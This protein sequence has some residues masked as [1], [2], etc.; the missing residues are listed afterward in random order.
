[1]VSKRMYNN[2]HKSN[3]AT[4]PA[5]ASTLGNKKQLAIQQYKMLMVDCKPMHAHRLA[6]RSGFTAEEEKNALG[7]AYLGIMLATRYD[8]KPTPS[9]RRLA[10][11]NMIADE[12]R[13]GNLNGAD[14]LARLGKIRRKEK[15]AA[16]TRAILNPDSI[17][18]EGQ[19]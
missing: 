4:A 14:M 1:M 12:A 11:L 18:F 8:R 15:E 6:Q 16:I 5:N 9:S 13:N 7:G 2:G 17:V 3:H 10:I 19:T